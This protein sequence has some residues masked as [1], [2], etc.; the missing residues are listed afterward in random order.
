LQKDKGTLYPYKT[1]VNSETE[2][3]KIG[4]IGSGNIG[5]NAAWLFVNAGHQV[6]ASN[7][8]APQSL[9][10]LVFS[11]ANVI[12]MTVEDAVKFGKVL[13]LAIPWRKRQE[14]SLLRLFAGKIVIDAT[15]PYSLY[16]QSI[17]F[18]TA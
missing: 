9:T 1:I 6:A 11:I 10:S 17:E 18:Y 3:M 5:S 8:C 7:S 15:N 12:S 2:N 14:L 16:L 13:L 4:I